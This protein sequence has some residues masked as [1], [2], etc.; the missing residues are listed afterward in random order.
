MR[1]KFLLKYY[2]YSS[3]SGQQRQTSGARIDLGAYEG[4]ELLISYK[5]KYH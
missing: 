2:L 5:I 4:N 1:I 3:N